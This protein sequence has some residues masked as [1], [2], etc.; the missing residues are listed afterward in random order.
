MRLFPTVISTLALVA[1][2]AA[3][4]A[5]AQQFDL[6][7][8]LTKDEF[9]EFTADVGSILRFRQLGGPA[10]LGRGGVDLSVQFGSTP[11][12]DLKFP[13]AIARFGV[14]DRVD[15]G[16]WGGINAASSYGLAGF[17]TNI[18][19]LRQGPSRPV[20]VSIRPSITSLVG[21]SEVWVGNAS[22]DLS[23]SRAIGPLSPYVGVATTASM[24][25]ERSDDVNLDPATTNGSVAYAGVSY[26]WRA[27]VMSAEVEDAT[28]TRYGFRVGTR[29]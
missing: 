22:I 23:A 2:I 17:D 13:Q 20:S 5:S 6:H 27:L 15:V 9:K 12:N 25:I 21:P 1:T 3:T 11:S 4:P 18:A 14:S 24:A 8:G 10:T 19:L 28:V 29:F 16:A 7:P 26:R